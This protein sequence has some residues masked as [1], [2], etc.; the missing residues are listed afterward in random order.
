MEPDLAYKRKLFIKPG[1]I[2]FWTAT[3]NKWQP[4]L[5]DDRFKDVIIESLSYLTIKGKTDVF[6]FVIMPNHVHLIWRIIENNGGESPQGSFLKYTAHQFRRMLL[7]TDELDKYKVKMVNKKHMFWQRDSLAVPLFTREVAFQKLDYIHN[8][9][10]QERWNLAKHPCDY[11]YSSAKYYERDEK[12]F[13][14]LKD[15]LLEI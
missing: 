11:K 10:L 8:N 2:C 1:E 4:L 3:I 12:N 7:G 13:S 5:M 14:F 9:P 6:A 15:L